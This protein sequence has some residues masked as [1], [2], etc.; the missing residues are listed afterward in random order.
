MD[1]PRAT[2]IVLAGGS[3]ERFGRDKL[4]EPVD[5]EPML[6]RAIRALAPLCDEVLVSVPFDGPA[7]QTPSDVSV[8]LVR[9]QRPDE[10]PL[11]GLW[12][13]LRQVRAPLALVVAGDMPFLERGV[14]ELLLTEAAA[15]PEASVVGLDDGKAVLPLPCALRPTILDELTRI[16]AG[17]ERRLRALVSE[18]PVVAVPLSSWIRLDPAGGSMRDVDRPEDIDLPPNRKN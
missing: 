17:G 1:A 18:F 11:I 16:T 10:G 14:L 2:G 4:A 8:V 6:H 15:H 13:T 7:P 9:D 5:G 3:S 12:S